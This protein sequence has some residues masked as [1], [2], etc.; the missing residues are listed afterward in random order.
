MQ[1]QR[2]LQTRNVLCKYCNFHLPSCITKLLEII[3]LIPD[4]WEIELIYSSVPQY[5]KW[6]RVASGSIKAV[7]IFL[8][9]LVSVSLFYFQYVK[10]YICS[11][12]YKYDWPDISDMK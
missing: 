1:T 2:H 4:D 11:M 8:F 3:R 5:T 10:Q 9:V 7:V 12:Y 6:K